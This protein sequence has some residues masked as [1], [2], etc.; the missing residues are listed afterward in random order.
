MDYV[1]DTLA[2]SRRN[3]CLI[4]V[5]DLTNECLTPTASSG[6]SCVQAT[7]ILGSIALF[8]GSPV[9]ISIY[10][11]LESTSRA[12]DQWTFEHG[13]ELPHIQSGKPT[14]NKF[15][16]SGRFIDEYLN[17]RCFSDIDHATKN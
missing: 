2:T 1:V 9:T 14:Q 10:Q 12:L 11:G 15:I 6:V 5:D 8:R 7:R 17:K 4:C 13:V 16:D 3:K